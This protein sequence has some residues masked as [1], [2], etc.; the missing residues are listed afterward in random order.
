MVDLPQ[1]ENLLLSLLGLVVGE[2]Y[3]VRLGSKD[4]L[5]H[6][7]LGVDVDG[8]VADVE[9]LDDLGLGELFDYA[10]PCAEVLHQLAGVLQK[11]NNI[12]LLIKAKPSSG[13]ESER[14]GPTFFI[15]L[16]RGFVALAG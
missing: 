8:V 3:D 15:D 12:S 14:W 6:V 10:L 11:H 4:G 1:S 16:I 13:E 9:E 7:D 5:V 2:L